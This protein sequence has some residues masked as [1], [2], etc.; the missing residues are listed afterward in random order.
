VSAVARV[1]RVSVRYG[2]RA[3]FSDISLAL[4][5]GTLTS[6][7]G[8]N[9]SGKSSLLRVLA[10]VQAPSRGTVFR[11]DTA[12]IASSVNPPP[13]VSP[14]DLIDYGKAVRR[15]WWR[16]GPNAAEIAA[17]DAALRQT[18]LLERGDDPIATL[19]DG[20]VQRAWI[21]AAM[22]S[23]PAVLLVDEP[24][25]H[26]DLR[27]QL[28]VLQMLSALKAS[29]VAIAV[30][31]HDLTLAARFADRIALLARGTLIDGPPEEVLVDR[32]VRE[33]YGVGISIH[34]H[35]TEG[36]LVCLPSTL[37]EDAT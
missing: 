18:G 10:G 8:P 19:S 16:L 25:S 32:A 14:R 12:L 9:G 21:A 4:V 36:Y 34:R 37:Q 11:A 23:A 24:T 7:V 6:I 29:G 26:L 17:A 2:E 15:P 3:V 30:A 5:P 1:E 13:D 28:E 35:P 33:A 27:Y 22:A 31:L 20:E